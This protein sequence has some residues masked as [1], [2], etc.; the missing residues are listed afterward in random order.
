MAEVH[1]MAELRVTSLSDPPACMPAC[2]HATAAPVFYEVSAKSMVKDSTSLPNLVGFLRLFA[3][4]SRRRNET[5]GKR[6]EGE[7]RGSEES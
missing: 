2:L 5:K 1:L 3:R 6:K 7:V 4:D